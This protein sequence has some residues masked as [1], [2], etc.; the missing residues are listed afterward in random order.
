[1]AGKRSC[2]SSALPVRPPP[3]MR[4]SMASTTSWQACCVLTAPE[5]VLAI[6]AL[7]LV[8]AHRGWDL[9]GATV[10]AFPAAFF[11]AAFAAATATSLSTPALV[12]ELY[13]IALASGSRWRARCIG[14]RWSPL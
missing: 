5:H 2:R 3:R 6:V 7:A 13:V 14:A 11:I 1:M 8:L 9:L 4:R 10:L 12:A